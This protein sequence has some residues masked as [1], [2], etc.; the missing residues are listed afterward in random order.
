MRTLAAGVLAVGAG[1]GL[2]PDAQ[3]LDKL[4]VGVMAHNICIQNCDSSG[5]EEG[6]NVELQLGWESPPML[7][8][9]FS[10]KPYVVA[11]VNVAGDTSYVGAGLDWEWKVTEDW[12]IEPGVGYIVHDGETEL[13]YPSGTPEAAAFTEEHVL[14]GSRDLF[15]LS[16]N[17]TRDLPGPWEAQFQ[18][19]HISHGQILGSGRNQGLDQ[20]GLRLV[21]EFGE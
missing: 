16:I 12:S 1:V 10:P 20:A 3:A 19:V 7:D 21:Y 8:F 5:R 18:V 2:A 17:V 15:R 9:A 11:S 13:P 4:H 6:P 14:L